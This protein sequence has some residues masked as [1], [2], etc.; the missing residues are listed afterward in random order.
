MIH[1][2]PI[3]VEGPDG[4]P[5]PLRIVSLHDYRG[6]AGAL[7]YE[8]AHDESCAMFRPHPLTMAHAHAMSWTTDVY[9]LALNVSGEAFAYG[10]LRGWDEGYEIPSLGIAVCR[11]ARGTGVARLMMQYLHVCARLRGAKSVRLRVPPDN[12][13]AI[14][15]YRSM[16]Y[17]FSAELEAG[18]HVALLELSA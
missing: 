5:P 12:T 9:A 1:S 18:Q 16:G 17:Q 3:S 7:F 10:I 6:A 13:V 15:L 8:V 4:A 14:G 11:A 2:I